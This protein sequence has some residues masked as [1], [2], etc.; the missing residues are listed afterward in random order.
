MTKEA[1]RAELEELSLVYLYE[2][3]RPTGIDV[4]GLTKAELIDKV[5]ELE[6]Q[7]SEPDETEPPEGTGEGGEGSGEPEGTGE[8][9]EEPEP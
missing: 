3:L 5:L 1:R 2:Q 9:S 4:T 7:V 6:G 8:G